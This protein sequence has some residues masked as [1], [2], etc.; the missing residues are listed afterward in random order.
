M[1]NTHPVAAGD[2]LYQG[3]DDETAVVAVGE[4]ELE[5]ATH[6]CW[7]SDRA[8]KEVQ[9]SGRHHNLTS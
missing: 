2:S 6:Q 5:E 3:V 8:E 4:E 7:S 1:V 9:I